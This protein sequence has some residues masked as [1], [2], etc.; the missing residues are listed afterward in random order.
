M[1]II[2]I[3]FFLPVILTN[4]TFEKKSFLILHMLTSLAVKINLGIKE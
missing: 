1:V 4:F 2:I 3:L